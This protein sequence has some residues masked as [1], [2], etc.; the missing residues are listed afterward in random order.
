MRQLFTRPE[1]V[2]DIARYA[3]SLDAIGLATL[4][5]RLLNSDASWD[6]LGFI[7]TVETVD[8]NEEPTRWNMR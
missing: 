8:D 1:I 6:G 5:R 2:R 3:E 4:H 7:L